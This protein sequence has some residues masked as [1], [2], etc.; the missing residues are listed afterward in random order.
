VTTKSVKSPL[1]RRGSNQFYGWW[2]VVWCT[3][4]FVMTTPGQTIGISTFIDHFIEDL[5][6]ERSV[7]ST[8][9]LI[10][11]LSAALLAPTVGR[12][13]DSNGV[14]RAMFSVGILLGCAAM[15][16]GAVRNVVMLTVGFFFIRL[17]GQGALSLT[18]NTGLAVWFEERR[19]R[20]VAVSMSISQATMAMAPFVFTALIAAVG[21]RWGFVTAGLVVVTVIP[22][23]AWF[24]VVDRPASLGQVPDGEL[25]GVSDDSSGVV[26]LRGSLTRGEA[27]RTRAFWFLTFFLG[28]DSAIY[29]GIVFHN[30]SIMEANGLNEVQAAAVFIPTFVPSLLATLTVGELT[31]RISHRMLI[32][33]SGVLMA[34]GFTL[35][36]LVEPGLMTWA[37][38][39]VFGLSA[40]TSRALSGALYPR[41]FGAAHIGTIRGAAFL[42]GGAASGIG[43]L[44]VSL[45]RDITGSYDPVMFGSAV[46]AIGLAILASS[47]RLPDRPLLTAADS[48]VRPE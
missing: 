30:V 22:A 12:L 15:A 46:T 35:V 6:T 43:P 18:A 29:T 7:V 19:G 45:G 28:L 17:L 24:M 41:F 31:D 2:M 5:N 21:W 3:I 40:G 44:V 11:T 25:I 34:S 27:L 32:L 4:A 38:G 26:A 16:M 42:I 33:M 20:A 13:I 39:I 36:T 9:Y 23:M 47:I 10:G 8:A 48:Y 14:R 37:Y 1:A